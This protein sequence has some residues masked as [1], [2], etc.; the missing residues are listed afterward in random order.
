MSTAARKKH[1][2]LEKTRSH[3]HRGKLKVATVHN[4][5][6]QNP[7]PIPCSRESRWGA[8]RSSI[9]ETRMF[10]WTQWH[11]IGF[12]RSY[13]VTTGG[14]GR[15]IFIW[16]LALHILKYRRFQRLLPMFMSSCFH[17]NKIPPG[18]RSAINHHPSG[19]GPW[20]VS[21]AEFPSHSRKFRGG[22]SALISMTSYPSSIRCYYSVGVSDPVPASQAL[23]PC[24]DPTRAA[25]GWQVGQLAFK[26]V[27]VLGDHYVTLME[28]HISQPQF[29]IIVH[30]SAASGIH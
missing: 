4:A 8:V 13:T 9:R 26:P 11:L 22:T 3:D 25:Q 20:E 21:G 7:S 2:C 15:F 23:S 5:D 30:M 16:L 14:W 18:N 12:I 1:P 27:L 10:H 28:G 24:A 29:L 19:N 17:V 6:R